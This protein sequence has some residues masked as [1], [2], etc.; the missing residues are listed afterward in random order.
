M[1]VGRH[2][3]SQLGRALA[4][5][6]TYCLSYATRATRLPALNGHRSSLGSPRQILPE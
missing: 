3:P 6:L 1:R 5:A 4:P 2:P